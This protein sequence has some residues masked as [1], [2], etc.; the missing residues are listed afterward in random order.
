[1]DTA[2]LGLTVAVG[3][4]H[5]TASTRD[6]RRGGGAS[7]GTEFTLALTGRSFKFDVSQ[8]LNMIYQP[9]GAQVGTGAAEQES[10]TGA[11]FA[12]MARMRPDLFR[13]GKR[14]T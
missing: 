11:A 8:R 6:Q 4:T 1:V 7:Y 10:T 13:V 9:E 2:P 12:L 5:A 14:D 3:E